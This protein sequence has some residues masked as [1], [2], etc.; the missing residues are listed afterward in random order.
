MDSQSTDHGPGYARDSRFFD[1]HFPGNPIVPGA[2]LLAQMS[3]DLASQG[4]RITRIIRM[5]FVRP[6]GPEKA[7]QIEFTP[8]GE[9]WRVD[10]TDSEGPLAR[11]AIKIEP[12]DD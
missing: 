7:F 4:Y 3:E 12:L 10:V 1:G 11:A 8:A 5:K 6:L 2:I 9:N